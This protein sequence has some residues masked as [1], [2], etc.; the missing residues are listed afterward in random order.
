MTRARRRCR[1]WLQAHTAELAALAA[2]G[3]TDAEIARRLG[4]TRQTIQRRRA[5]LG[6]ACC[7][8]APPAGGGETAIREVEDG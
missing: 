4:F 6:L 1:A 8:E 7:Y 2:R 5:A 3:W